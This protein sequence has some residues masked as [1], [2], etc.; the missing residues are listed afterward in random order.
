M[1]AKDEAG[2][3]AETVQAVGKK[4]GLTYDP[5]GGINPVGGPVALC[6]GGTNRLI[7]ELAPGFW[8]A[9]CDGDEVAE[10]GLFSKAVLPRAVL[11]KSHV[12]D[13]ATVMPPFNVESVE[14]RPEE[15]VMQHTSRRKVEF[16]S[17]EFNKRFLATVP[18]E[19]DPVALRETFSPG[20][21]EWVTAIDNEVEFGVSEQQLWFLWRLEDRTREQLEAALD[22]GG[23]LFK[24]VRNEIEESGVHTYP[25]GPW[26]AGLEPFPDS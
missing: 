13:L 1:S 23:G 8:G 26:H 24:R 16:E 25:A 22:N 11:A 5:V 17:I 10:G 2:A 6:P 19:Y 3:W 18:S 4:R 14:R 9:S 21:L 7:G 15:L 12:P 20:F